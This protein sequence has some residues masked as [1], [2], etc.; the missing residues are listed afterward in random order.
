MVGVG[1]IVAA[2][3]MVG[4]SLTLFY[5]GGRS[6]SGKTLA[7]A[8]IGVAFLRRCRPASASPAAQCFGWSSRKWSQ[9]RFVRR[10]GENK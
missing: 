7:E 8:A 9:M 5:E 2:I 1:N 3:L 10:A 6:D 4:A